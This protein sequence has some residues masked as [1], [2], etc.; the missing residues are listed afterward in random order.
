MVKVIPSIPS[1]IFE[2]P[3][4]EREVELPEPQLKS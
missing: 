1:E 2:I 4:P 3:Q